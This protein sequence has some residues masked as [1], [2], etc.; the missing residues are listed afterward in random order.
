MNSEERKELAKERT[1]IWIQNNKE[2]YKHLQ[3]MASRRRLEKKRI[4][5]GRPSG[6]IYNKD[7]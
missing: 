1:R 3:R 2:Y 6:M 4:A 5:E 7:G